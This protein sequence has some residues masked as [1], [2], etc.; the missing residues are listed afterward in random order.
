MVLSKEC[1]LGSLPHAGP[2]ST[3]ETRLVLAG[4]PLRGDLFRGGTKAAG[5]TVPGCAE[6][7]CNLLFS[8]GAP[9][10]LRPSCLLCPELLE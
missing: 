1:G 7:Q 4:T 3:K 9:G 10:P 5:S 6:L 2:A 8:V